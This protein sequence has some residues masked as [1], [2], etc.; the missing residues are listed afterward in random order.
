LPIESL[1]RRRVVELL[2]ISK[3]FDAHAV[4]HARR[5]VSGF[6]NC[7]GTTEE[8]MMLAALW[9]SDH[10]PPPPRRKPTAVSTIEGTRFNNLVAE[11]FLLCLMSRA[12]ASQL[13]FFFRN[14]NSGWLALLTPT[15]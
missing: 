5:T 15:S 9:R 8:Q 7:N 12:I 6:R 13:A 14:N 3:I 11:L 4:A 10:R 1:F 2:E